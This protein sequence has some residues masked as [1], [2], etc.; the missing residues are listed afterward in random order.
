MDRIDKYRQIVCDFLQE[1]ATNDVQAQLIFDPIR[2]G[3][4]PAAGIAI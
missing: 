1:F 3:L 4:C 2:V